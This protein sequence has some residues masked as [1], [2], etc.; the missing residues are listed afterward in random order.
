MLVPPIKCQGIKTRLAGWIADSVVWEGKG[1]WIEPFM[2]S[3]VVGFNV[4]PQRAVFCDTNRHIIA[5][6]D[7]IN[8]G[9]IDADMV[10][11]Y[12]TIEGE[13]L[14]KYGA[15]YYYE[16]RNRFNADKAPLDFLFLNRSCFNGV[17]RFNGNGEFNVPFCHKPQ[18]FSKSYITKIANQVRRIADLAGQNEWTFERQDFRATLANATQN[19]FIYCDPPYAGRHAD[20]YN[21]WNAADE[22]A[23]N[24]CLRNTDARFILSTWHS[25]Q[26]RSNAS[27]SGLWADFNLITKEHFYHVGANEVNRKPMLEALVTNYDCPS[28]P[29]RERARWL[30]LAT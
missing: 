25:N 21:R 30:S 11:D 24:E 7:A 20:Y 2:G 10:R 4:A 9:D 27:L 18:R 1:V 26:H 3:G 28:R 22:L 12:L 29:Y 23:L 15:D 17:I 13:R 5:F 14:S 16:V 19:D 8:R 6:Y